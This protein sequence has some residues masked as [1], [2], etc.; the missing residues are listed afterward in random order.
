MPPGD[1]IGGAIGGELLGGE[2]PDGLQQPETPAERAGLDEEHRRS[3]RSRSKSSTSSTS[4]TST[5]SAASSSSVPVVVSATTLPAAV[6]VEGPGE[7]QQ[8]PEERLV[9]RVSRS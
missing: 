9:G 6:T 4:T 5:T 1:Q 2:L 8:P 3:T 7:D